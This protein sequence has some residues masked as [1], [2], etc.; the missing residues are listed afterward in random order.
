VSAISFAPKTANASQSETKARRAD[1]CDVG[2]NGFVECS[3]EM[4]RQAVVGISERS[5]RLNFAEVL[6][7]PLWVRPTVA[8]TISAWRIV[9]G[10]SLR[11]NPLI[12]RRH[13]PTPGPRLED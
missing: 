6:A 12:E 10:K 1:N 2:R 5:P 13:L 4:I 11:D 9:R 8:R 3:Q 7:A